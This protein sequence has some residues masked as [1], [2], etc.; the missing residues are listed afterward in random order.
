[1][2]Y[3]TEAVKPLLKWKPN[4]VIEIWD[5]TYAAQFFM[6]WIRRLMMTEMSYT[7]GKKLEFDDFM[8]P[9]VS[10]SPCVM[11]HYRL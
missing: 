9:H 6:P 7:L 11:L 2:T 4:T 3:H 8:I 1:M 5:V 10:P